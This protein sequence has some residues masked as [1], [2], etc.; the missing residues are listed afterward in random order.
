MN[1]N[2]DSGLKEEGRLPSTQ[3]LLDRMT[4]SFGPPEQ[5]FHKPQQV[6]W[7]TTK[8]GMGLKHLLWEETEGPGLVRP[9]EETASGDLTEAFQYLQGR[10]DRG[11]L[12]AVVHHGKI[13]DNGIKVKKERFRLGLRQKTFALWRQWSS[14]TD[15]QGGCAV[16][17][18]RDF[19]APTEQSSEQPGLTSELIQ[20]WAGGWTRNLLRCL[21]T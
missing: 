15:C 17:I 21:L 19:Q 14:G 3:H 5:D 12:F 13:R 20:L 11:R 2:R 16:S 10:E 1:R 8:T 4:S 18:S 9:P 6:Q 7:R